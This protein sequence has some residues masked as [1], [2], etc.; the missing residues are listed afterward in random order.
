MDYE[1]SHLDEVF[2]VL[3]SC[4]ILDTSEVTVLVIVQDRRD[5]CRPNVWVTEIPVCG[6]SRLPYVLGGGLT[7]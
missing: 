3:E 4:P 6:S 5:L 1:P 7:W 2:V